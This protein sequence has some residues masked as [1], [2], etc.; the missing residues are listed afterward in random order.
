MEI[1]KISRRKFLVRSSG[2]CILAATGLTRCAE[3]QDAPAQGTFPVGHTTDFAVG[4]VSSFSDGQFIVLRDEA[5]FWAMTAICTHRQCTV[6][7]R[8]NDLS[9]PCHH[10]RFDFDGNV[11]QGPAQSPLDNLSVTIDSEDVVTVDT[12]AI[13][14]AGTRT[15]V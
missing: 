13:V 15:A 6:T 1:L 3:K 9:C 10:S 11:L 12:S 8:D 2:V 4:D 14:P 7:V 5:G